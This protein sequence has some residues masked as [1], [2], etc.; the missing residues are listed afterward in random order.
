[1]CRSGYGSRVTRLARTWRGLLESLWFLPGAILVGCGG[2]S[3]G[4]VEIDRTASPNGGVV[5]SGN[6]AAARTVLSVLAGSLITVAGVSL[7]LTV[8]VLQLASSQFSPRVLPSFLGDRLTQVTVGG[9]VGIFTFSLIALRAVGG[10]FVPRLTVTVA[11]GLGVVAVLLLV[12]FIHH[13]SKMIQVSEIAGRLGR[14][15]ERRLETLYPE[16][17][18][19]GGDDDG[20]AGAALDEWRRSGRPREVGAMRTGYVEDANLRAIAS[21]LDGCAARVHVL[22]VPGDFVTTGETVAEYWADDGEAA[23][24][25]IRR[26]IAIANERSLAVDLAF[27]IRQ[28][29]DVALRA[30]SPSLN[31]PTTARTCIGYLRGIL[32]ELAG[33]DLP[34]R[35]RRFGDTDATVVAARREFS[36]YL[37]ALQEIARCAGPAVEVTESLLAACE[38]IAD[39]AE[40]AGAGER[41]LAARSVAHAIVEYAGEEPHSRLDRERIRRAAPERRQVSRGLRGG[42]SRT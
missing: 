37:R 41:A 39:R 14:A 30:L 1:M 13:V 15:T 9:F 7:S 36:D 6:E 19:G 42:N 34:R 33:R 24:G 12:A 8:L 28:L 21:A 29:T 16:Q 38:S 3:F 40:R 26:G 31:D 17:F 20:G 10:G 27:G 5:F 25:A 4:L 23:E 18:G 2:L 22:V 11:S 32:E 35:L